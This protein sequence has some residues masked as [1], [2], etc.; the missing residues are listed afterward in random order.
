[1][2]RIDAGVDEGDAHAR[3]PGALVGTGD[4]ERQQIGLQVIQRVVVR[5]ARSGR[6][7]EGVELLQRLREHD[8]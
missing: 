4:A 7:A 1:M 2:P 8:A 5:R 6:I 3:A